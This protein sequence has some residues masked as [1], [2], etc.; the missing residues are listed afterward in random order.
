MVYK[1]DL[2]PYAFLIQTQSNHFSKKRTKS[3]KILSCTQLS[4]MM[5]V[6]TSWASTLLNIVPNI[7]HTLS[8][9]PVVQIRKLRHGKIMLCAQGNTASEWKSQDLPW[10]ALLWRQ[11]LHLHIR[12]ST[13]RWS[14][15][16]LV[17]LLISWV[18][19]TVF[20][21]FLDHTSI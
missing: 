13:S 5:I 7:P 21:L 20:F 19:L 10:T 16:F 17:F 2:I 1:C 11:F 3:L 6:A 18:L 4:L 14:L 8:H 15:S 12:T 9:A